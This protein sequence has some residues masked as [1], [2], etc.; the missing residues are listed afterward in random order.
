M[1]SSRYVLTIE[2]MKPVDRDAD[3]SIEVF[4]LRGQH[5][6]QSHA[7]GRRSKAGIQLDPDAWRSA[8]FHERVVIDG[9]THQN[10]T[11]E[12]WREMVK[13]QGAVDAA[14]TLPI[15]TQDAIITELESDGLKNALAARDSSLLGFGE[16]LL[17]GVNPETSM[18]VPLPLTLQLS[19]LQAADSAG[20]LG[21]SDREAV[22]EDARFMELADAIENSDASWESTQDMSIYIEERWGI[23]PVT[24]VFHTFNKGWQESSRSSRSLAVQAEVA[25]RFN[26]D[27]GAFDEF[28]DV[29]SRGQKY[30]GE[31]I[32]RRLPQTVSGYVDGTYNRTQEFLAETRAQEIGLYRGVRG[33]TYKP[34]AGT[35]VNGNPISSWTQAEAVAWQFASGSN[36]GTGRVL[37]DYA[38][39][40]DVFSIAAVT[41][42]G[43]VHEHEVILLGR[44]QT[45]NVVEEIS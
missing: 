29:S 21:P 36:S 28:V 27:S 1:S 11:M 4:H 12:K 5:D 13:H 26:L 43:A 31:Y 44:T 7:G 3:L 33:D 45:L 34:T 18:K 25:E 30:A 39:R 20:L 32:H 16:S 42:M 35:E 2:D 19:H 37:T 22:R 41:G 6:Q 10:V 23:T 15:E 14:A 40:E 9:Q 38:P 24:G 17:E 8:P